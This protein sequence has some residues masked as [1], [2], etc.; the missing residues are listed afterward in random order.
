[1]KIIFFIFSSY[2]FS[3]LFICRQLK[4]PAMDI[5]VSMD[6]NYIQYSWLQPT[7]K[8]RTNQ[9][10]DRLNYI[11]YSWLQPT[12]NKAPR[13]Q[14]TVNKAAGLQPTVNKAAGLQPTVNKAAVYFFQKLGEKSNSTVNNSRRPSSI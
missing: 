3:F 8:K 6:M 12:V 2:F 4:Q 13:L 10:A 5:T 1:M 7:V 14:P 11:Y 9:I